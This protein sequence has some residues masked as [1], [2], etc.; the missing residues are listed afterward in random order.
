M[1]EKIE[2]MSEQYEVVSEKFEV[3]SEKFEVMSEKFGVNSEYLRLLCLIFFYS[4][5]RK[6]SAVYRARSVVS[7]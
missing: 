7:R 2:V 6:V 4:K 5:L 3:M 1:S